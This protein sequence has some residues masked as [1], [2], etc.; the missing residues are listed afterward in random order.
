MA[1]FNYTLNTEVVE[2]FVQILLEYLFDI[3]TVIILKIQN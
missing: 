3:T 2:Y 1:E